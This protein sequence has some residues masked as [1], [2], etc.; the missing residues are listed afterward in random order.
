MENFKKLE[1]KEN[2]LFNRKEIVVT[3]DSLVAPSN[4][5]TQEFLAKEFSVPTEN[6]KVKKILGRFG[7]NIFTISA[8]LYDSEED[9]DATEV[10]SKKDRKKEA[11]G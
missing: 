8:N 11:K 10:K 1:E 9:K 6:I 4:N 2:K 3:V 5:E 7:S